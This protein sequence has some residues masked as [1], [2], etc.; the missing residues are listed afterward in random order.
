MK[1]A[2]IRE[3]LGVATNN[4]AEYRGLILGLKLALK[5]GFKQIQVQGDSKLVCM[6]VCR[7]FSLFVTVTRLSSMLNKLLCQGFKSSFPQ[8][9]LNSLYLMLIACLRVS[10]HARELFVFLTFCSRLLLSSVKFVEFQNCNCSSLPSADVCCFPILCFLLFIEACKR[11][12]T[13]IL[14]DLQH[15]NCMWSSGECTHPFSIF[16]YPL[17]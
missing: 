11:G 8:F 13:S 14:S 10:C 4:V 6:Q 2:R 1:V 12:H 5:K 3:G 7:G 15:R 17:S 16:I 9:S